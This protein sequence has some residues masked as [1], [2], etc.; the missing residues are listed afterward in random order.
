VLEVREQ[1][2]AGKA[3][4]GWSEMDGLLQFKGKKFVPNASTT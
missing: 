3:K 2:K 4:D 1:L